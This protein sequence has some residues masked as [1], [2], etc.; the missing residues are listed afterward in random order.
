[1]KNNSTKTVVE[2]L[3][4]KKFPTKVILNIPED[5]KDFEEVEFDTSIKKEKYD[6]MF[7]FIYTLGDFKQYLQDVVNKDLL[8]D[9]GYLYFAYPKK[10][11]KKYNQYIERDAIYSAD[12]YNEEGFV[13]NSLLKF[14]KMA[15]FN[16]VFTVVG[17]KQTPAKKAKK[18]STKASQCVDDYIEKVDDLKEHW[19]ENEEVLNLY[20]ELTPGYQ[21]DWAR[22]VYSAKRK[23]TQEKRLKDMEMVLKEGYKTMD[24]YRLRGR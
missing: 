1:M 24:L 2:K 14:S 23:E 10:N 18:P 17:M 7:V 5:V 20:S 21:K 19:K 13:H 22:Y 8:N 15:S 6:L 11:N 9:N 12:H 4:F 16:E 3:S